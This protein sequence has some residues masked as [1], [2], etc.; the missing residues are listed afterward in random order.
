MPKG[1]PRSLAHAKD[2]VLQKVVI[3]V[4]NVTI[5]VVDGA[6]GYG[7]VALAGLPEGNVLF[8]GA[9]A[10]LQLL[11]ADADITTTFDGDYSIGTAATV[12]GDLADAN[13]AD[14]IPSTALGA[15]TAK[16]SPVVRGVSTDAL[17]GLII[18]NTANTLN[19]NLNLLIDD[20]AIS[21][22]ANFTVN[23]TL[24]L[25]YLVLGDD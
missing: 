14:I 15:A 11:T 9:V 17:G 21:G 5:S 10:Y 6:P 22:A 25:A 2:D 4:K 19:F 13:E 18:D 12:D 8:L 23:G 1:L 24:Y 20:A 3:P 16:L 7:S